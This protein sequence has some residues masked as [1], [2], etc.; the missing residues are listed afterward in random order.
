MIKHVEHTYNIHCPAPT[1][2]T[3]CFFLFLPLLVLLLLYSPA[4]PDALLGSPTLSPPLCPHCSGLI[5][6]FSPAFSFSFDFFS[7]F[8]MLSFL[9]PCFSYHWSVSLFHP[10]F[11]LLL[12]FCLLISHLPILISRFD[13]LDPNSLIQ[14]VIP[15]LT[16]SPALQ[17]PHAATSVFSS[18]FS[19]LVLL[20]LR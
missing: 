6:L 4:R 5:S 2:S 13:H 12:L 15:T 20:R 14:Q 18:F 9:L 7:F 10:H 17:L 19:Q 1:F 11:P 8:F 16:P 3:P